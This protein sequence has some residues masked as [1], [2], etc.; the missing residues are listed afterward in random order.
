MKD[1][2]SKWLVLF[3]AVTTVIV[4]GCAANPSKNGG[5]GAVSHVVEKSPAV[6]KDLRGLVYRIGPGDSL[7][8]FYYKSYSTSTEYKLGLGDK[9]FINVYGHKD[10]S[11]EVIILPDG[12]VTI[13]KYGVIKAEGLTASELDNVITALHRK[14]LNTPEVDVLIVEAQSRTSEFLSTLSDGLSLGGIKRVKVRVDGVAV[15]PVIGG[16][17]LGGLT[18]AEAQ[19]LIMDKYHNVLTYVAVTLSLSESAQQYIAVVGEVKN[20]GIYAVSN[21]I[22]PHYALALAGGEETTADLEQVAILRA[23]SDGSLETIMLSAN[24]VNTWEKNHLNNN[25]IKAGDVVYVPRTGV[26]DVNLFIDQ[27]IR[28]MLPFTFSVGGFWNLNQ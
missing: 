5:H 26:S 20:P 9:L 28:R 23:R 10:L 17:T 6:A 14:D 8:A 27:Y 16:V 1:R 7:E 2:M 18:I 4:S 13:P 3:L 25:F 19:Q 21:P 24:T 12:A 22:V 11:R 15:F